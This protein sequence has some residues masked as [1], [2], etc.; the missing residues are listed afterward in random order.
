MGS[1]KTGVIDIVGEA[2]K[3]VGNTEEETRILR[4]NYLSNMT[5]EDA[6]DKLKRKGR[7]SVIRP[8][9][10]GKT[11]MM[12][13][14][15][16]ATDEETGERLYKKSLYVYPLDTIKEDVIK[17]YCQEK[18]CPKMEG[19]MFVSYHKLA[20]MTSYDD[21]LKAFK[22]L[23][24]GVDL[25][26]LDECHLCGAEGFQAAWDY[27][28]KVMASK[29]KH[30]KMHVLGVTASPR[31]S[32]NFDIFQYLGGEGG[33]TFDI[34]LQTLCDLG[35]MHRPN[36][37]VALDAEADIDQIIKESYDAKDSGLKSF[38][39]QNKERLKQDILRDLEEANQIERDKNNNYKASPNKFLN[40]HLEVYRGD[41]TQ[42]RLVVFHANA[43]RLREDYS[44][45]GDWISS[46]ANQYNFKIVNYILMS[47]PLVD[48]E[49][50]NGKDRGVVKNSLEINAKFLA[51]PDNYKDGNIYL[52]HVIDMLN[53]GYHDDK[54]DGVI[55]LRP[56]RSEI[57][58]IQQVGR[59]QSLTA[60]KPALIFDLVQNITIPKYFKNQNIEDDKSEFTMLAG[61]TTERNPAEREEQDFMLG[62]LKDAPEDLIFGAINATIEA[63]NVGYDIGE[64][65][66]YWYTAMDAPLYVIASLIGKTVDD[67][68]RLRKAYNNKLAAEEKRKSGNV[69]FRNEKELELDYLSIDS[70]DASYK[71]GGILESQQFMVD[72][73]MSKQKLSGAEAGKQVRNK[74]LRFYTT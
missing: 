32:D 72:N 58:Q 12:A 42:I 35:V 13:R 25:I 6:L 28:I 49:S 45:V 17:K 53:M 22:E 34:S 14:L 69:N 74:D 59:C 51:N 47:N 9:G 43:E 33:R 68:I 19:V 41:S 5:F 2:R 44:K 26:M 15:T 46:F 37:L 65:I 38:S 11:Y 56:T 73:R 61:S 1:K 70:G 29:K 63:N 4:R 18:S 23:L 3:I 66:E 36:W 31:R 10:F 24:N 54:I 52:I 57:I 40:H 71:L 64:F 21:P 50:E 67:V 16:Q 27:I 7:C 48:D 20:R 55:M 8:T 39:E 60:E 30:G 62:C